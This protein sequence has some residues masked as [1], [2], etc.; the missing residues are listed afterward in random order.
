MPTLS[1]HYDTPRQTSSACDAETSPATIQSISAAD[2]RLR[3]QVLERLSQT[4]LRW[5]GIQIHVENGLVRLCGSVRDARLRAHA[6]WLVF[7][8]EGVQAVCSDWHATPSQNQT[9][10]RH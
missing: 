5:L 4:A 3:A 8:T 6:E 10:H 9:A 1:P 7:T 2:Q